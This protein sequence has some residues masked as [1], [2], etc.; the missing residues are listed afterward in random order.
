MW[1]TQAEQVPLLDG[2]EGLPAGMGE[3]LVYGEA[4]ICHIITIGHE[5]GGCLARIVD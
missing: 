5:E 1:K 3:S 4:V 2:E